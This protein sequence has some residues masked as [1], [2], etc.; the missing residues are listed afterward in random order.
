MATIA[1][2]DSNRGNDLWDGLSKN[3]PFRTL[4]R[5][6]NFNAGAGGGGILLARDSFFDIAQTLAA[7]NA[8]SLTSQF[9]GA[10]GIGNRAFIDA[11]DPPGAGALSTKPTIRARMLPVPSDWSWD[12]TIQ[13]GA[14]RGW[15]LQYGRGAS[16]WDARV[17]VAGVYAVT[18]NQDTTSGNG[19]GYINGGQFGNNPGG[20][21]NGMT[22]DTL[23][24]NLD[25]AGGSVNGST[26]ARIYIS[27]AGLRTPGVG[28]DPSSVVGP[29]LIEVSFGTVLTLFDAGAYTTIKNLRV[30]EGAGLLIYQAT[31]NTVRPGFE[32]SDVECF[33]T[34]SP[35]RLNAGVSVA[36]S[37]RW[38]ID[39]HDT[40][41]K[42]LTGPALHAF[43]AGITGSYRDNV[44]EDGNRASSIGGG[45]YTQIDATTEGGNRDP[46]VIQGNVARRWRN[47][48]G[49][50]DFDGCCFYSEVN[51]NGTVIVGNTA[52]DS[53]VA[54]QCNGGQRADW[55]SNKAINCETFAMFNNP[56]GNAAWRVNDYRFCNNL[57]VACRRGTYPHG[58]VTMSHQYHAPMFHSS[59]MA[60]D[61]VQIRFRNNIMVNYPGGTTEV[62]LLLGSSQNWSDG[63]VSAENNLFIGYGTRLV[64]ADFGSTNKTASAVGTLSSS[65][66]TNWLDAV[67][68]DY[69][70]RSGSGLIGA[71]IE[72]ARPKQMVDASG[73]R[74]Q[75]PPSV[76]P[77]E[78]AH[79]S[80]WFWV[81]PPAP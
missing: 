48:A 22:L 10:S 75:S 37:N 79:T 73:L 40:T 52:Y 25:Y 1:Y 63:K 77:H 67:A 81:R 33:D 43:G 34:N 28:N 72:F 35:F 30:I 19:G 76:G 20:F 41:A 68:N 11:Y 42:F 57:F 32:V 53:F 5:T 6:N 50:C 7:S 56:A 39:I 14:P 2:I 71:G 47:G 13:G 78:R 51:D 46:F 60:T 23:R 80:D 31:A 64:D 12:S 16:H 17:K 3:T 38:Q 26:N 70:L 15:Y 27:G 69:R 59:P 24:F 66:A 62:P 36:A 29:G 65:T 61:L 21:V 54:F 44:L 55:Y 8:W 4:Q 9:N 18:M 49:N 74:Y 45:T 58:A